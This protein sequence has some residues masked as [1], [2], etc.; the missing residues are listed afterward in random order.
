MRDWLAFLCLCGLVA[1]LIPV[2]ELLPASLVGFAAIWFLTPVRSKAA[3]TARTRK[4]TRGTG[5]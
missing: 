1:V 2:P 5:F 3:P 4:R